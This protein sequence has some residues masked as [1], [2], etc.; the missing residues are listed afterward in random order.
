MEQT[1]IIDEII[2]S[3]RAGLDFFIRFLDGLITSEINLDCLHDVF[4]VW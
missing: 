2:K 1:S 4:H 3:A